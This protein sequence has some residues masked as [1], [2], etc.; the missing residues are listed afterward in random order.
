MKLRPLRPSHRRRRTALQKSGPPLTFP[1]PHSPHLQFTMS[2]SSSTPAIQD[3]PTWTEGDFVLI[4]S[5]GWRFQVLSHHLFSARCASDLILSLT[6]S[7]VFRDAPSTGL[8]QIEFTDAQ[9]ERAGVVDVALGLIVHNR[10]NIDKYD[11]IPRVSSD[12]PP[13][14]PDGQLNVYADVVSFLHKWDCTAAL[15]A[16]GL[17]VLELAV[18]RPVCPSEA[19]ALGM[20]AGDAELCAATLSASSRRMGWSAAHLPLQVWER[21]QP[22][23]LWA[24]GM[25]CTV[26]DKDSK[27]GDMGLEFLR[28]LQLAEQ[29][30]P[31]R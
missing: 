19:L 31:P 4:S 5:D 8:R 9:L 23:F 22:K 30:G 14:L 20:L 10:L 13:V 3:H 11:H 27:E 7:S 16:F 6:T 26:A 21:A 24:F 28:H 18:M 29:G 15:R 2:S 25:A 12:D 1:S 17:G